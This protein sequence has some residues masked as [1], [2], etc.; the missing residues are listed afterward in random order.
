MKPIL[1]TTRK[2][3]SGSAFLY[4]QPSDIIQAILELII[5]ISK[6]MLIISLKNTAT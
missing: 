2:I 5:P 6:T 3:G 1:F 4:F